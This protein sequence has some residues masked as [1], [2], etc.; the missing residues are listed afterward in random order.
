MTFMIRYHSDNPSYKRTRFPLCF[1]LNLENEMHFYFKSI[2]FE[3]TQEE[4]RN[5]INFHSTSLSVPGI[6]NLYVENAEDNR[7]G[8]ERFA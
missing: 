2:L 7:K 4:R 3:V 5:L 8:R 6:R 1:A